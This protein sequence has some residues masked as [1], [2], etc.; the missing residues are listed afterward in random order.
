M[1]CENLDCA[2]KFNIPSVFLDNDDNSFLMGGDSSR[3]FTSLYSFG[4]VNKE[5]IRPTKT[6]TKQPI[7]E[8]HMNETLKRKN[9]SSL[10]KCYSLVT[11][12]I[13]YVISFQKYQ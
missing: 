8:Y 7:A 13:Y 9:A 12:Y 4:P 5:T 3:S 1:L 11:L 6:V 2:V 10:K